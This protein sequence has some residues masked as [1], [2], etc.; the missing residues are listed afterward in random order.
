MLDETEMQENPKRKNTKAILTVLVFIFIFGFVYFTVFGGNELT[1]KIIGVDENSEDSIPIKA[2]LTIPEINLNG[3]LGDIDL[4]AAYS[5]VSIEDQE[6]QLSEPSNKISL[7][8]FDGKIELDKKGLNNLK[9][10]SK[11][12]TINNLPINSKSGKTTEILIQENFNLKRLDIKNNIGISKIEYSTSGKIFLEDSKSEINLRNE[13][14]KIQGFEG[15]LK[16]E[17]K[18]IFLDGKVKKF[19]VKGDNSIEIS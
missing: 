17:N 13:E 15:K 14:L 5:K 6:L 9:G 12:I 19:G 16:I 7:E 18:K 2:E 1:G 11:K 4:T 10:D 3:N 8:K